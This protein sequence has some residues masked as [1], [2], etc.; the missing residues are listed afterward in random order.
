MLRTRQ[1][2]CKSDGLLSGRLSRYVF[3]DIVVGDLEVD[4]G[5]VHRRP[6][7]SCEQQRLRVASGKRG[8]LRSGWWVSRRGLEGGSL[9][10]EVGRLV[11]ETSR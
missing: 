5:L 6:R 7:P 11:F 8:G 3:F 2:F 1:C 10:R 9:F 4:L